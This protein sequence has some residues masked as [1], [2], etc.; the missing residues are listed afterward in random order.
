M[1]IGT[2]TPSY[3]LH[4]NGGA[5]I[6]G[7]LRLTTTGTTNTDFYVNNHSTSGQGGIQIYAVD[8]NHSIFILRGYDGTL[9]RT[10]FLQYGEFRWYTTGGLASQTKKMDLTVTGE[11]RLNT[12][13][14]NSAAK[15][16]IRQTSGQVFAVF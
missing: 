14:T 3:K 16:Q 4:V 7:N 6:V 12:S 11:L 15:L 8:A 13:T 10:D 1:C 9:N 5:Y 2:T